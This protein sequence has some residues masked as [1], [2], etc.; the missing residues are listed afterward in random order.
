MLLARPR[1]PPQYAD[2]PAVVGFFKLLYLRWIALPMRYRW[3]AAFH[4]FVYLFR[5]GLADST[6]LL[7]G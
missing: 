7:G 5:F 3:F 6:A 4:G 1:Q 2:S